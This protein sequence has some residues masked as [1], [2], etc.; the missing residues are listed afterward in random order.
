MGLETR[1]QVLYC[2]GDL[3]QTPIRLGQLVVDGT[4]LKMCT[5]LDPLVYSPVWSP[6]LGAGEPVG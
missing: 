4:T 5:S 1:Y 2:D 6:A 3:P